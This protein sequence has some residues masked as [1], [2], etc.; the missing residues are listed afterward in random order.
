MPHLL[1]LVV[2]G[3]PG[4]HVPRAPVIA[5]EEHAV[6]SSQLGGRPGVGAGDGAVEDAEE[7]DHQ[8]HDVLSL[9]VGMLLGVGARSRGRHGAVTC[10]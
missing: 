1:L 7:P 5:I 10:W 6:S 2:P 9:E 4:L 8:A 3:R